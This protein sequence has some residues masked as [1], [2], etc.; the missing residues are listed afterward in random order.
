MRQA[1]AE[2]MQPQLREEARL[3]SAMGSVRCEGVDGNSKH[4]QADQQ[5][6]GDERRGWRPDA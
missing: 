3:G 2:R 4:G 1:L 5:N 6:S